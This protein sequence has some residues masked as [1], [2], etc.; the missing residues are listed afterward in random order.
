MAQS[1]ELNPVDTSESQEYLEEMAAKGSAAVNGG[2]E[3]EAPV[4]IPAK[5]EG[6]PDK[7]YNAETG[8]V[9]YTAL[10]KSYVELE[11]AR[12]KPTEAPKEEPK[13]DAKKTEDKPEGEDAATKAVTDAGLDMSALS[14]EYAESGELSEES[15]EVL[16]KAGISKE[17]VD[18]YIEGK[19]AQGEVLR[20][21][22]YSL[23]EGADGYKAMVEYAK[24]NLSAEEI[25]DYNVAVNSKDSKVREA[26]V[27]GLWTLY[28]SESG[29]ASANLITKT[30]N[31]KTGD[32][33]YQS[34]QEMMA[35]MN[36]PKYK[37]DPA[38]RAKVETKLANSNIF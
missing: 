20:A 37:S 12:S 11:K 28:N 14:K 34:R 24:A 7:F 27:K 35:D 23:T 3:P 18:D 13:V 36:D 16:A 1:L 26:A 38:F 5:P 17:I 31:S 9:D 29:N 19:Q 15:Y 33:S 8:V 6:I 10:A 21:Q 30:T 22:A 4:E 32:G 25:A 2:V